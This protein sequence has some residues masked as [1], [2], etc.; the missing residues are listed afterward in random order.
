MTWPRCA[1]C[2]TDQRWLH[3]G[4]FDTEDQAALAYDLAALRCRGKEAQ[5]NFPMSR[6][7]EELPHLETV[8]YPSLECC[9]CKL[10]SVLIRFRFSCCPA[11]AKR[12]CPTSRRCAALATSAVSRRVDAFSFQNAQQPLPAGAAP[13]R[14]G[15]LP[16][17]GTSFDAFSCKEELVASLWGRSHHQPAHRSAAFCGPTRCF[18]CRRAKKS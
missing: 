1:G 2:I 7:E 15:V 4:G 3:A 14:G 6:Y 5:T 13:P 18:A 8:R 9:S 10:Q 11:A 12:S 16:C 17:L